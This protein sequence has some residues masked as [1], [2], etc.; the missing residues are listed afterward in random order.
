[1]WVARKADTGL[2]EITLGGRLDGPQIRVQAQRELDTVN[3]FTSIS[4][5][6]DPACALFAFARRE[7]KIVR[8][9]A[10]KHGG[11]LCWYDL[12]GSTQRDRT[13]MSKEYD[14]I[15]SALR[16]LYLSVSRD[17]D[18]SLRLGGISNWRECSGSQ[19]HRCKGR[20]CAKEKDSQY[21]AGYNSTA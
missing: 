4:L 7:V 9:N 6:A 16:G 12:F 18:S 17:I 10:A 8:E 2:R 1:M 11:Y 13:R 19:A 21:S 15:M 14:V 5:K 20:I 3:L